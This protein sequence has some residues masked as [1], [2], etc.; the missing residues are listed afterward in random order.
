MSKKNLKFKK[1]NRTPNETIYIKPKKCIACSA[2]ALTCTKSTKISV[3]RLSLPNQKVIEPKKETFNKSNCIYCGQCTLFCPTGAINS[4]NPEEEILKAKEENKY[5]VA[6]FA[7]SLKATLGEE[8]NLPIG[9]DVSSKLS[10]SARLA[11][12]NQVFETDFGADLTVVE[13]AKELEQRIKTNGILP[14]FTSCCPAWIKWAERFRPDLLPYI[15]TCKSPQQLL[16]A[17][18]KTYFAEKNNLPPSDIFVTSI[19]PCTA[20]KFEALRDG[21]G[22]DGYQDV[23]AVFTVREY[24]KYLKEKGID[25]RD[26]PDTEPDDLLGDASGGAA[27]FGNA[28]GVLRSTLRTLAY[29]LGDSSENI[30]AISN[31]K[32]NYLNGFDGV[33]VINYKINNLD[34]KAAAVSGISNLI[35]FLNSGEWKNYHFIEVMACP[36]GCVNGG[37]T[38]KVSKKAKVIEPLCISCG[39]C[40]ENCPVGAIEFSSKRTARVSPPS[41][42]GCTLCNNLC[43]SNAI[44]INYFDKSNNSLLEESYITLRQNVLE[45]FDLNSKVRLPHENK[46]IKELYLSYLGDIGGPKAKSILHI[47]YS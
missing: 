28:G 41:C 1:F 20:K 27:I 42:V 12:F 39:T 24:A 3:L 10:T 13:E 18:I 26:I 5:M 2:C 29:Y 44:N 8:F 14:M 4:L 32:L 47:E 37:G 19:K 11:G 30:D 33:K 45:N 36:G 7:P 6:I 40:I 15:S 9:T 23:D 38:P 16:G 43:R 31:T 17:T 35:N 34:I 21:M 22:R 46:D 25:L